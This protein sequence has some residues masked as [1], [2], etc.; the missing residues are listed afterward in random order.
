MLARL[1]AVLHVGVH[2]LAAFV[3]VDE[4]IQ[5]VLMLFS[6]LLLPGGILINVFPAPLLHKKH[7]AGIIRESNEDEETMKKKHYNLNVKQTG[8]FH[9]PLLIFA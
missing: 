9:E 5:R 6:V 2:E 7:A 3:Q 4:F 1:R 8:P